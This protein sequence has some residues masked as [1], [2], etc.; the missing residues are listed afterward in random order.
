MKG[1]NNIV[2]AALGSDNVASSVP[3]LLDGAIIGSV[4]HPLILSL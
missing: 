3:Q 4:E 1:V 2:V